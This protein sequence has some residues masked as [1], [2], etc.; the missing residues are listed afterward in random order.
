MA[1]VVDK[2][3]GRE[4]A[5]GYDKKGMDK[6]MDNL[7]L[8]ASDVGAALVTIMDSA[9]DPEMQKDLQSDLCKNARDGYKNLENC[10]EDIYDNLGKGEQSI[11]EKRYEHAKELIDGINSDLRKGDITG[12]TLDAMYELTE[13][14]KEFR[15]ML[16]TR[17]SSD[18]EVLTQHLWIAG[19][20]GLLACANTKGENEPTVDFHKLLEYANNIHTM[21]DDIAVQMPGAFGP[22]T[23]T[24]GSDNYKAG[25][26]YSTITKEDFKRD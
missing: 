7:N 9:R 26:R 10:L 3:T 23:G 18:K 19:S 13:V 14:V 4:I 12:K 1:K 25:T 11:M 2:A 22:R 15:N 21:D 8:N 24:L 20:V 5:G 17:F 6:K 16:P